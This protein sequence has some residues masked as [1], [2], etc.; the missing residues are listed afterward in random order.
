MRLL[1]IAIL[2]FLGCALQAKTHGVS[3]FTTWQSSSSDLHGHQA[4]KKLMSVEKKIRVDDGDV[5]RRFLVVRAGAWFP[6]RRG[7]RYAPPP[8]VPNRM[9]SMNVPSPPPPHLKLQK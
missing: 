4:T 7:D 6:R 5:N 8:P 3:A 2:V 9:K 1:A